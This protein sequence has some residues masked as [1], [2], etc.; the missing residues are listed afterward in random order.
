[1]LPLWVWLS[2]GAVAFA[3]AGTLFD[4]YLL[5]RYFGDR[6]LSEKAGPG[7]L[8]IFS[9]YFSGFILAGLLIVGHE[10][11][12]V[13]RQAVSYALFAGVLN[14]AWILLY[15]YAINRTEVS[16]V[17]PIFQTIPV[18]GLM[19]AFMTLGEVLSAS[20]LLAIGFMIFGALVLLYK[21]TNSNFGL[22]V[23]TLLLMLGSSFLVALSHTTFKLSS[24]YSNYF[25][26]TIWLWFG[27]FLSGVALH[28]FVS[29]YRLEFNYL[30]RERIK[31]VVALN[32]INEVLNP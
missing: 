17:V 21:K 15:L 24:N 29:K 11:L 3:V 2:M 9:T 31:S 26:A 14:G 10:N 28:I 32:S 25:T 4:K 12:S 22:D 19:L 7:A 18:F 23:T 8:L 6:E 16:R 20:Q 5:V 13:N 30:L 27:F 1:M